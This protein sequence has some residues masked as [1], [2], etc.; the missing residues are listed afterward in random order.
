MSQDNVDRFVAGIDAFNRGDLDV[1]SQGWDREIRFEHRL[2][3]L[4]GTF[5]GIDA[6][7]AWFADAAEMLDSPRIDCSDV[8]DLGHQ[9]LALG[10]VRATGRGSGAETE[11]PS[12]CWRPSETGSLLISSTTPTRREP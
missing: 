6:V 11:L 7:M 5:V 9:V 4:E 12:P 8:R 1:M 10:T 2:A 3:D